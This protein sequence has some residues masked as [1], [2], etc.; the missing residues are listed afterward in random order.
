MTLYEVFATAIALAALI[1]DVMEL[2]IEVI[3]RHRQK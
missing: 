1:V 2:L 3:K